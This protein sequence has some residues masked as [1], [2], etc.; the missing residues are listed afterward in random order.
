MSVL[1]REDRNGYEKRHG[2]NRSSDT[3]TNMGIRSGSRGLGRRDGAGGR[4]RLGRGGWCWGRSCGC[5]CG[6]DRD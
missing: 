6:R 4:S 2:E 1:L 5:G 3:S